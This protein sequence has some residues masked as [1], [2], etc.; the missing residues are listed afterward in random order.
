MKWK[1]VQCSLEGCALP[2]CHLVV[3]SSGSVVEFDVNVLRTLWRCRVSVYHDGSLCPWQNWTMVLC[4]VA[5]LA[6]LCCSMVSK[7]MV[8]GTMMFLL[9]CC[10]QCP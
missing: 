4:R 9:E 2:N 3:S 10:A 5:V 8:F 6:V 1:R 7:E